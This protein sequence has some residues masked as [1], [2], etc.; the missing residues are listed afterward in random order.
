M[1]LKLVREI[2]SGADPLFAHPLRMQLRLPARYRSSTAA[3]SANMAAVRVPGGSG[4]AIRLER[5]ER[6]EPRRDRRRE[7]FAQERPKRLILPRLN[8]ARAP[9][10]YQHNAENVIARGFHRNARADAISRPGDESDFQFDV[11]HARGS[12]LRHRLR[13]R[14]A[15][16]AWAH[17]RRSVNNDRAGPPVVADRNPAPIRQQ[18]FGVGAKNFPKFVACSMEE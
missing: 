2:D 12:E 13:G 6:D 17:D 15:L 14:F 9:V 7:R 5:V 11:Q 4:N 8:V 3:C 1:Y 18:R 16:A 10:V